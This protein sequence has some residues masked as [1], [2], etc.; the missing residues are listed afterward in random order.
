MQEKKNGIAGKK[1]NR[2]IQKVFET[3]NDTIIHRLL[4]PGW[5]K[6]ET[7]SLN[8]KKSKKQKRIGNKTTK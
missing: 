8:N 1:K 6:E 4:N 3:D 2:N 7:K 5:I